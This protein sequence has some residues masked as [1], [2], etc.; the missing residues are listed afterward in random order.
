M[1]TLFRAGFHLSMI[2]CFLNLFNGSPQTKLNTFF[3]LD[4]VFGNNLGDYA[5][6]LLNINDGVVWTHSKA[7][8]A[9]FTFLCNNYDRHSNFPLRY[10]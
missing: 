3:A 1:G 5:I 10:H 4:T 2:V 7:C 9:P 8:P 6:V